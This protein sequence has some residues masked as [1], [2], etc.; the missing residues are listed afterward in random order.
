[1]DKSISKTDIIYL[2]LSI[3]SM[4]VYT[5]LDRQVS[6]FAI[7]KPL[8][9]LFLLALAV[10]SINETNKPYAKNIVTGLAFGVVGDVFLIAPDTFVPGLISFL[11]G[12][13]FYIFAMLKLA[14]K[15]NFMVLT[16]IAA[17]TAA[18]VFVMVSGL[19][20]SDRTFL[21]L[22][23]ICY[24]AVIALMAYT[25]I[26]AG[27]KIISAGVIL[28]LIS[29]SILGINRFVLPVPLGS[30]IVWVTYCGAQMLLSLSVKEKINLRS[31]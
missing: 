29:D 12:H 21:I 11:M 27:E 2:I 23:V 8:S 19:I 20:E 3:A 24:G 14:R 6:L 7:F 26:T 15:N 1:M 30:V 25:G 18:L 16:L 28:F 4:I 13:V 10:G 5:C 31:V 22:P 17:A 9:I